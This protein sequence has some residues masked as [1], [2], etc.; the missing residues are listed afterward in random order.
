[1][2]RISIHNF[3]FWYNR[4]CRSRPAKKPKNSRLIEKSSEIV[5]KTI[6]RMRNRWS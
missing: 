1:M 6:S 5:G 4:N 3:L 2:K